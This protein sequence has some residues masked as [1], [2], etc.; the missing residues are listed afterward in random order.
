VVRPVISAFPAV[1][2]FTDPSERLLR[3]MAE[4]DL[5][6]NLSCNDHSVSAGFNSR[7]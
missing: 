1:Q 3:I 2:I 4:P 7:A 5:D 6:A